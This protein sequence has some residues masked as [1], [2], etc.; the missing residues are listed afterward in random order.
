M[1]ILRGKVVALRQWVTSDVQGSGGGGYVSAGSGH[2]SN[3]RITTQHIE[4]ASFFVR[5]AT[6]Q[7]VPITL[8]DYKIDLRDDHDVSLVWIVRDGD[9]T[10]P[11][12]FVIN[13]SL[14]IVNRLERGFIQLNSLNWPDRSSNWP[15]A[16]AVM[17]GLGLLFVRW[18]LGVALIAGAVFWLLPS[19][20]RDERTL[21]RELGQQLKAI[22]ADGYASN[23]PPVSWREHLQIK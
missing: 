11:F 9:P 10:G 14:R 12:L 22:G 18:Y 5:G 3:I 8:D 20:N 23:S 16:A 2:V 13:H 6:G 17:A 15:A 1:N 19:V 7:E 21:S 4:H